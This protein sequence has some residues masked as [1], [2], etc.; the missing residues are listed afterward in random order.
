MNIPLLYVRTCKYFGVPGHGS[1]PS[2]ELSALTRH[3]DWWLQYNSTVDW[4]F[5][6][7]TQLGFAMEAWEGLQVFTFVRPYRTKSIA[8]SYPGEQRRLPW[9]PGQTTLDRP[10]K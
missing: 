10:P 7:D 2:Q 8:I 4:L 3:A 9:A 5:W 6:E 1:S